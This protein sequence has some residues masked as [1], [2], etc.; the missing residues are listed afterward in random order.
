[1]S[2]WL[3]TPS[4]ENALQ[5]MRV[6]VHVEVSVMAT[7]RSNS[8]NIH[9]LPA[10]A[11]WNL[12]PFRLSYTYTYLPETGARCLSDVIDGNRGRSFHC[13][14]PSDIPKFTLRRINTRRRHSTIFHGQR[15]WWMPIVCFLFSSFS[16]C[17]FDFYL[18]V[19]CSTYTLILNFFMLNI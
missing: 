17:L 1:M 15:C 10:Y 3:T 18:I 9:S 13:V 19:Q 4:P 16:S 7:I 8:E 6:H 2:R 11:S 14:S 12:R 5:C